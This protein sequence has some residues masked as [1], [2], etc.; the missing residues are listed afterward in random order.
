MFAGSV[1]S[2]SLT[3]GLSFLALNYNLIFIIFGIIMLVV[4][5]MVACLPQTINKQKVVNNDEDIVSRET[6]ERE[7]VNQRQEQKHSSV[8]TS[9]DHDKV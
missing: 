9:H 8:T 3:N 4:M 2:V 1:Y 6:E 7:L 5:V